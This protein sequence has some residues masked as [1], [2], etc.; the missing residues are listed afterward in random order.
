MSVNRFRPSERI[1]H[2]LALMLCGLLYGAAGMVAVFRMKRAEVEPRP[3]AGLRAVN[4]SFAQME[5]RAAEPPPPEPVAEP[6]PEPEPDP[7]PAERAVEKLPEEPPPEPLPVPEETARVDQEAFSPELPAVT[8]E[9][10]QGETADEDLPALAAA[11]VRAM[12]ERE[13]YYPEA[14]RR[15]GYTGRFLVKVRLSADGT[16]SGAFIEERRGHP[17]LARAVENA[18][19][20]IQGQ[21]TGLQ[22]AE[23]Q[24]IPLS[25]EFE[26]N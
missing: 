8:E 13:K 26:L 2:F 20:R 17:L 14:A 15:S 18:L 6:E 4:L 1:S 23:P 21:H 24:E 12:I 10:L 9:P 25:I 11:R 16:V 7:E 19:D 3:A 5:L 22:L